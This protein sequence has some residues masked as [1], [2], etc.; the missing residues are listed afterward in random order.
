[1][2][3]SALM[4]SLVVSVPGLGSAEVGFDPRLTMGAASTVVDTASNL[5]MNVTQVDHAPLIRDFQM[6]IPAG[7]RLSVGTVDPSTLGSCVDAAED[8][9]SYLLTSPKALENMESVGLATIKLATKDTR[10]P[11]PRITPE[12][13]FNTPQWNPGPAIYDGG[14]FLG[15]GSPA[16]GLWF[17]RWD[18]VEST[19]TLC[20][21]V[22]TDNTRIPTELR[23]LIFQLDLKLMSDGSWNLSFDFDAAPGAAAGFRSVTDNEAF[24]ASEVSIL[25]VRL[26]ITDL[27]GG[28][29][30][31]K[32]DGT[33]CDP[34]SRNGYNPC[35]V[36]FSRTPVTPANY[37]FRGTFSECQN[38]AGCASL[39]TI[40]EVIIPITNLPSTFVHEAAVLT[41]PGSPQIPVGYGFFDDTD[42][43]TVT[44][45]QPPTNPREDVRAYVLL[46][47]RAGDKEG[48]FEYMILDPADPGVDSRRP[49]GEDGRAPSCSLSLAFPLT[50]SPHLQGEGKYDLA[51]V[52]IYRDGHRTDGR[53]DDGTGAGVVC[54]SSTGFRI[55]PK[56]VSTWEFF[57]TRKAWPNAFA[58]VQIITPSGAAPGTFYSAP[59]YVLLVDFELQR[60]E[61]IFWQYVGVT[62]R[63]FAATSN[64]I[65]GSGTAGLVSFASNLSAGQGENFRF[66]GFALPQ[67]PAPFQPAACSGPSGLGQACGLFVLANTRGAP[68]CPNGIPTSFSESFEGVR[69]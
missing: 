46:I 64:E 8:F 68:C 25:E 24:L 16:A 1:M 54:S 15:H 45:N 53:C 41:G 14:G 29:F 67:T 7:W 60:G 57:I 65:K 51:L 37:P 39:P 23:E 62:E 66:D 35:K 11:N 28:N 6:A 18:P 40:R 56:G 59:V 50:G 43:V 20:G 17:H 26:Q 61:F 10:D 58:E 27:T 30:Q 31:R 33:K 42:S 21:I 9:P 63:R 44:W 52:T 4:M 5:T 36:I 32:A 22:R 3:L 47:A 38:V 49:C 13:A 19:A 12:N 48:R 55:V 2:R 69:L 34:N